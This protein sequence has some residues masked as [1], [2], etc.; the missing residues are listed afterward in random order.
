MPQ[1]AR[2]DFDSGFVRVP[3]TLREC[4]RALLWHS[5]LF[6]AA[7]SIDGKSEFSRGAQGTPRYQQL[8]GNL[9][10]TKTDPQEGR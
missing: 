6:R 7:G 9:G 4:R 5:A 10:D 2:R 8:P 3:F 1:A